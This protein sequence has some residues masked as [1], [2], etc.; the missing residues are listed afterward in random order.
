MGPIQIFQAL[1]EYGKSEGTKKKVSKSGAYL[2]WFETDQ[3]PENSSYP[4]HTFTF[5][6]GKY[7]DSFPNVW[8]LHSS[9][10]PK[11]SSPQK[12]WEDMQ[13]ISAVFAGSGRREG[14]GKMRIIYLIL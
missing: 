11:S 1:A 4:D 12:S 13:I 2:P 3:A 9:R 10:H 8:G 14:F 6:A 5:W 7:L